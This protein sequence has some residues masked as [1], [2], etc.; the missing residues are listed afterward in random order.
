MRFMNF[1]PFPSLSV[2]PEPRGG[3]SAKSRAI[4]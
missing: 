3:V 2:P 4:I 1:H